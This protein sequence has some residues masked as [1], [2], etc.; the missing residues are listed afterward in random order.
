MDTN[1]LATATMHG[2]VTNE[3]IDNIHAAI[4][5]M[6][7]LTGRKGMYDKARGKFTDKAKIKYVDGG[8]YIKTNLVF[9]K[10]TT[11]K[12]TGPYDVLDLTPQAEIDHLLYEWKEAGVQVVISQKEKDMNK[13]KA[14][15][16]SLINAKIDIAEQSLFEM[17]NTMLMGDGTGN[18]SKDILGLRALVA[19]TGSIGGKDRAA[20]PQLQA[21][22]EATVEPLAILNTNGS[23]G[24]MYNNLAQAKRVW[25]PDIS[26]TTQTL[27]EKYE[28]LVSPQNRRYYKDAADAGID[29]EMLTYK[30]MP[31]IYDAAVPAGHW[32]MLNT[33]FLY[34]VIHPD[35]DFKDVPFAEPVN[36]KVSVGRIDFMGQLVCSQFKRQGLLSGKTA[37]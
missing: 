27:Y 19:T 26:V 16:F 3:L 6:W 28:S 25:R 35:R 12:S 5:F 18:D 21:Q 1:G 32:Y 30:G 22:T 20:Y 34:L 23:L 8:D 37:A 17:F 7:F 24:H 31:I 29:D 36:Q 4:P 13:G 33:T 11:A 9:N 14:K 10:N 15:I 2:Y